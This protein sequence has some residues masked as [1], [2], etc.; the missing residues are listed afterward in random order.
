MAEVLE[1]GQYTLRSGRSDD[2]AG[3]PDDGQVLG[4]VLGRFHDRDDQDRV[5][6]LRGFDDPAARGNSGSGADDVLLLRP[7]TALQ[8]PGADAGLVTITLYHLPTG[9]E[10]AFVSFFTTAVEPLLTATGARPL[11]VLRTLRAA[12][13]HPVPAREGA[14]VV[15]WVAS[16]PGPDELHEHVRRLGREPRWTHEILPALTKQLARPPEQLQLTPAAGSPLR[17]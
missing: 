8:S 12:S 6:W 13:E 15:V 11:A 17:W 4:R 16:F 7:V 2:P 10:D 14:N 3:L 1:L 5:V 9:G